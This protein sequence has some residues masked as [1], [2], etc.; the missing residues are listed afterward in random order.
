MTKVVCSNIECKHCGDNYVC[1][2]DKV[3]MIFRSMQTVNEGRQQFLQCKDFEVDEEW[4]E[5]AN[6][7]QAQLFH[8]KILA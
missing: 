4:N 1:D 3:K 7:I 6:N 2:K 5:F 8:G